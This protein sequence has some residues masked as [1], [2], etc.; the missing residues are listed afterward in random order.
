GHLRDQGQ[1]LPL[2][3]LLG[4]VALA[5][6]G[7]RS[8]VV[9]A[10]SRESACSFCSATAWTA[11]IAGASQFARASLPGGASATCSRPSQK[12][13]LSSVFTFNFATPSAI[14]ACTW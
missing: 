14:A 12:A 2:L 9:G 5:V 8:P 13:R 1:Q 3:G 6:H 4:S 10:I 7:D 11:A